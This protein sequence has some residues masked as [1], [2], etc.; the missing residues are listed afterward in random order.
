MR[1]V[2]ITGM[3]C[4]TPVGNDVPS[5]W[6]SL[7]EGV[8]GTDYITAFDASEF[9]TRIAAEVKGFDPV[10]IL[11]SRL[12]KH[13]GRYSQLALTAAIEAMNDSGL[14]LEKEDR[15]RIGVLIG[16]GIGGLEVIERAMEA[17][18]EKGPKHVSPFAVPM[19]G[20]N[21]AAGNISIMFNLKGPNLAVTSACSSG[22][23]ALGEAYEMIRRGDA[24][25]MVAGA[26][27]AV[28]TPLGIAAF[29]AM[30]AISERNDDPKTASRPF[31]IDRDGFV[32]GEGA[33][34]LILESE[35]HALRR[36]GR[37]Y[38]ELASYAA[39]ADAYHMTAPDPDG[40]GA[41]LAMSL[42]LKKA[43]IMPQEVDYINAHGTSTPLND[44]T[45]TKAIR[46]VFGEHAN[47]IPVSST[48]SMTGH[49]IGAAGAVESIV[50]V[51]AINH[52][53]IP[54]TINIF[55]QDP[56]CDLDYVPGVARRKEVKVAVNNSFGFGGHNACL[57]FKAYKQN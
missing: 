14:E 52:G 28:I 4:I 43:N 31:D 2:V 50:C 41:A 56:E 30:R 19:M 55:N 3:G 22:G 18:R 37:V 8:S 15:E 25:V 34:I 38:A 35:E 10:Q 44:K 45:E 20:V 57:V 5:T 36:G 42:A 1:R 33:G 12:A 49:M 17:L 27:E 48:K 54:P 29:S 32:V 51:L 53:I 26:T 6:A 13:N 40:Y 23:H 21:M 24:D 16:G 47:N 39:T 7:I 46:A 9:R 11:G